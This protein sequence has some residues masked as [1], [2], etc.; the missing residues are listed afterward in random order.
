MRAP[1]L[2][3]L[4]ARRAESSWPL[5]PDSALNVTQIV[6]QREDS[7]VYLGS[8]SV[9][10]LPGSRNVLASHD[11]FGAD[12]PAYPHNVAAVLS[13]PAAGGAFSRAGVGAGLYWATLVD[14]T[15]AVPGDAG[16][17]LMGV[18]DDG[19]RAAITI[20]RSGDGGATW[21]PSPAAALARNSTS[22]FYTGPTPVLL[23]AGR[24]WRAYEHN[25]G[26]GWASGYACVVMSAP[27]DAAD[28]TSPAAWTMSGEL[29]FAA[30]RGMVPAAWSN[31]SGGYNVAGT[32][33][34][35]EGNAVQLTAR[36][37]AT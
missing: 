35:L 29:P 26:P 2:F 13:A 30:V 20:A 17:Y 23:W 32:F 33:G 27:A 24:L 7:G 36:S 25:A 19:D 14:R 31:A 9:L 12:S 28:L 4:L 5:L 3:L 34:W 22:A 6:F 15:A 10:R 16:V 18:S 21:Q 11:W 1:L 37:K 8:P